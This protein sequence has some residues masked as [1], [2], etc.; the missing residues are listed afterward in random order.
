MNQEQTTPN[1]DV[2]AKPVDDNSLGDMIR[3][4][5]EAK[6]YSATDLADKLNLGTTIIEQLEDERFDELPA[7]A[8][9]R[10]Y[11]RGVANELGL[12][13]EEL[14]SLYRR[15]ASLDPDLSSTASAI[16]QH[17]L[18][19]PMMIWYTVGVAALLLLLLIIWAISALTGDS[20][21]E[22]MAEDTE[23]ESSVTEIVNEPLPDMLNPTQLSLPAVIS[24]NVVNAN[25]LVQ[26]AQNSTAI[27]GATTDD[28]AAQ[29]TDEPELDPEKLIGENDTPARISPSATR[30]SDVLTLT[31]NGVSWAEISDANGFE[32]VYGLL[33]QRNRNVA[34]TGR[35]PFR[36]FLGDASQVELSYKGETV[37]IK[38]HTRR[39]KVARFRVK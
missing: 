28:D 5:R 17:E 21:A 27:N 4:A 1:I 3:N 38:P 22:D 31:A 32:L 8:F 18:N 14:L 25:A 37:D 24:S 23:F 30:G 19:D 16:R 12:D 35:A 34:L 2:E 29:A 39:N 7:P 13:V 20:D 10:G 15:K 26:G 33:D 6:H 9:V 11:L 36:V